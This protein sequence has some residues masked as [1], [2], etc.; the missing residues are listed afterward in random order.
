MTKQMKL[1]KNFLGAGHISKYST[2]KEIPI[3][4][5]NG[6]NYDYHKRVS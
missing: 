6:S 1:L 4:F 2:P 5:H 3:V